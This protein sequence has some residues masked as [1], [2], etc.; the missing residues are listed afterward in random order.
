MSEKKLARL[1]RRFAESDRRDREAAYRLLLESPV[2]RKLL[3]HYLFD[4]TRFF[5]S[6]PFTAQALTTSFNCGE[7]NVGTRIFDELCAVDPAAFGTLIAE[8]ANEQ[9]TRADERTLVGGT[10][11]DDA[12]DFAAGA[13]EPD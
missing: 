6:T 13:E 1:E 11:R 8:Q 5:G 3:R 2:G 9:R 4:L 12:G 7:Q 10:G